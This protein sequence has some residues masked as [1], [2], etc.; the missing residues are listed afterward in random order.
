MVTENRKGWDPNQ[1]SLLCTNHVITVKVFA[2]QS[3]VQ[4]IKYTTKSFPIP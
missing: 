1:G 3:S 2:F 4:Y